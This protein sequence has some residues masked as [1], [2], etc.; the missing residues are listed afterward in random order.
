ME[1]AP[2]EWA[3]KSNSPEPYISLCKKLSKLQSVLIVLDPSGIVVPIS[4]N[5][6]PVFRHV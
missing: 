2:V 4:A 5:R 3:T 6:I 1:G